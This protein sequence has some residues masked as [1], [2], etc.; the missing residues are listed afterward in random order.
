MLSSEY[1]RKS[2]FR[3]Y[4]EDIPKIQTCEL[5]G[6]IAAKLVLGYTE[7]MAFSEPERILNQFSLGED[8]SVA[9]FGVGSGAYA[10][11][12]ARHTHRGHIYAI[13]IQKNLLAKVKKEA[14]SRGSQNVEVIWGDVEKPGGTHLKEGSMDAV[15]IANILFQIDNKRNVAHEAARILRKGGR[16]L[17]VD[18]T[19]SFGGVGPHPESV[20]SKEK[21]Q[22]LF[23]AASFEYEQDIEAGEHHYG[24]IFKKN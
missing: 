19:G 20:F 2:D 21:A 8:W 14:E 5:L 1:L 22:E 17:I 4:S 7:C 18:W 10:L 11:A 6:A 23:E 15:I 13:D 24:L 3:R 16:A 12:A 9:D